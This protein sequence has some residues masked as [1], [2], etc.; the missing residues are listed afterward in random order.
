[1]NKSN[2]IAIV[3]NGLYV[4][5]AEKFGISLANKFTSNGYS[6]TIFLFKKL[7]SPL[8]DQINNNIEIVEI[9]RKSKFD[10]VLNKQFD[11]EINKR[12]IGKV[13]IIGL[14]PLFLSR[15]L[16]FKRNKSVSYFISLHSTIP[17]SF[18]IYLQDLI[19]L[20]FARKTDKVLFICNAQERFFKKI[21]L[22]NPKKLDIIYNG[23]DVDYFDPNATG[24]NLN[25]KAEMQI[26]VTDKVIL[27]V[28][29]IRP[30]KGHSYAIKA[31][32]KLHIKYEDQK[33][34]HLIFIGGGKEDYIN[35][36]K[37]EISENSLDEFIHFEGNQKDVRKYYGIA[38]IFTLTSFSVETFS[39]AALEA[40]S[41]GLPISL[42]NIGGAAEMV[43]E[44]KNGLLSKPRDVDSIAASWN[45]L[46]NKK[47]DKNIIR[48]IAIEKFSLELMFRKYQE[49]INS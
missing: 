3:F 35:E 44:G 4:G 49:T 18:R 43:F 47:F 17:K 33:T 10:I 31:L 11:E 41:Y 40:M 5:G 45:A 27:L 25:Q 22:F 9:N 6:T 28:A 29:T 19:Y 26:A 36:L 12:N 21:F 14:L 23:V 1:M 20:R 15:V 48:A 46:L 16:S 39:I 13:I 24:L 32:K 34:T 38:D 30:E 37:E 8:L 42:T 2:C 7:N